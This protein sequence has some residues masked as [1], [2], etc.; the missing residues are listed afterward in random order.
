M[1]P[2]V[3]SYV[4]VNNTDL[5]V[6]SS[7]KKSGKLSNLTRI[8]CVADVQRLKCVKFWCMRMP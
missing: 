6:L 2:C 8:E 4:R 3:D 7:D 5:L 1:Y